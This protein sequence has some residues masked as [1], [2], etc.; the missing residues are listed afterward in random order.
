VRAQEVER[1]AADAGGRLRRLDDPL[2]QRAALLVVLGLDEQELR[3]A[4]RVGGVAEVVEPARRDAR[5]AALAILL[6]LRLEAALPQRDQIGP[7][8]MALEQALEARVDL[9]VVGDERQQLLVVADCL[10]GLVRDV[11]RE[12]RGLA[13]E[14]R[15]PGAVLVDVDRAV[16]EREH[17]VPSLGDGEQHGEPLQR[18]LGRGS[19]LQ[20]AQ[21]DL[22]QD[23]RVVAEPLVAEA[24]RALADHLGDLGLECLGERLAVQGDD[25]VWFVELAG[26][27]FRFLPRAHG[28]RRVFDFGSGFRESRQIG[29]W[30]PRSERLRDRDPSDARR[31]IVTRR[32]LRKIGGC[33][34][35]TRS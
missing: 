19:E 3:G 20:H 16:V 10:L 12:L 17:V 8:V 4:Q 21:Q 18:R 2:E 14:A 9:R 34:A 35:N 15:A 11:L 31:K 28:V 6:R 25:V 24:A 33:L 13:Q 29:H 32:P 27:R 22:L 5:A 7:A 26:E 30:A 23:L 1:S